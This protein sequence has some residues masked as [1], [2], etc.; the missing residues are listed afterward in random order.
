MMTRW[1]IDTNRSRGQA[2]PKI[3]F[4]LSLRGRRAVPP[5]KPSVSFKVG[6]EENL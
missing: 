1:D 3:K 5:L 2:E 4:I 6:R